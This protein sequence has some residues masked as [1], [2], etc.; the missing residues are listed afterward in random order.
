MRARE[1]AKTIA[2]LDDLHRQVREFLDEGVRGDAPEVR[3]LLERIQD[4]TAQRA[5]TYRR[6]FEGS[7]QAPLGES[8]RLLEATRR[9]LERK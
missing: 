4:E 2:T 9:I 5:Q 3:S 7:L 1:E 6:A 8:E